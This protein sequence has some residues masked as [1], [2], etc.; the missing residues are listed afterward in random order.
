MLLR[1]L[2]ALRWIKAHAFSYITAGAPTG[3][4]F[5]STIA[6][7]VERGDAFRDA[8]RIVDRHEHDAERQPQGRRA[9]AERRQVHI[10]RGRVTNFNE[11]MLFRNPVILK[12][13]RFRRNALIKPIPERITFRGFGP[14]PRNLQLRHKTEFHFCAPIFLF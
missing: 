11:E 2:S 14:G 10:G 5:H 3:A 9:L 13:R 4:K 6:E 7:H 12:S 8:D 1:D